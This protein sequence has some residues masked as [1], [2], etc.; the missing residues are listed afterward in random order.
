MKLLACL[1][2]ARASAGKLDDLWATECV[3][4]PKQ[5]SAINSIAFANGQ[6]VAT[7]TMYAT[8]NCET[9]N[10]EIVVKGSFTEAASAAH[11]FD[12]TVQ[13]VEMTL[14]SP[15]VVEHYNKH[16]AC[17]ITNWALHVPRDVNGLFCDPYLMPKAKVASFDRFEVVEGQLSF[18]GFP[19]A[20]GFLKPE[21]RPEKTA[22][23]WL[24]SKLRPKR[25]F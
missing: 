3:F 14:K 5:H 13:S 6:Y 22:Q 23:D 4:V 12:H 21:E 24:Y 10:L 9:K 25:P 8:K 1:T 16:S 19:R 15:K 17:G 2:A 11:D 20:N 7:T 18:G